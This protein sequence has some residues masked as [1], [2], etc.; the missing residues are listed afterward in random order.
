MLD[1][2]N[3]A[4]EKLDKEEVKGEEEKKEDDSVYQD[5]TCSVCYESMAN[6]A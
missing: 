2:E 6:I 4:I 3:E 5:M 1:S